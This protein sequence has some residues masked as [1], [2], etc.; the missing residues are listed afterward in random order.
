MDK[1]SREAKRLIS[2]FAI[3]GAC[4]FVLLALDLRSRVASGAML[5][6]FAA[7]ALAAIDYLS[8]IR[9]GDDRARR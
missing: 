1:L 6:A 7:F 8:S 4:P 5:L 3:M 2:M 9:G